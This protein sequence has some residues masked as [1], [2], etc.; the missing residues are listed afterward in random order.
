VRGQAPAPYR[1]QQR[2][3][4]LLSCGRRYAIAQRGAWSAE[5]RWV[6]WW[7]DRIDRTWLR[8]LQA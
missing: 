8:S 1:P 2:A 5:G 3:L 6:W 7:K 4:M